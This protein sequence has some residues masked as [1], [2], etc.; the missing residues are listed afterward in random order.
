M[1]STENKLVQNRKEDSELVFLQSAYD[2]LRRIKAGKQGAI[3]SGAGRRNANQLHHSHDPKSRKDLPS[4][5]DLDIG[6][7]SVAS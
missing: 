1:T 3:A 4:I 6:A 2:A 7:F 5:D